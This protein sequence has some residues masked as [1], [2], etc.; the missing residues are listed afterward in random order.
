MSILNLTK[1]TY[2]THILFQVKPTFRYYV[3]LAFVE[4]HETDISSLP[5]LNYSF[6]SIYCFV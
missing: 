4:S 6:I 3:Y 2:A 5:L 1:A